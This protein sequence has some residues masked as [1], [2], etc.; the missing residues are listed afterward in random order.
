MPSVMLKNIAAGTGNALDGL[1][2]Q[3][4]ESP[5]G[6]LITLYASTPTAGG[7]ISYSVSGENFLVDAAVNIEGSADVVSTD[8]D[9]ILF[10]EPVPPGKQFLSVA[11]QIANILLVIEDLP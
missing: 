2:F 1:N 5:R 7:L 8:A 10:R 11:A 9:Q 6:A 3:N 4:I